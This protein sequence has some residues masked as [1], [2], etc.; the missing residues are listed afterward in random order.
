MIK[1]T[2]EY[3]HHY[4]KHEYLTM[5]AVEQCVLFKQWTI[6]FNFQDPPLIHS[7]THTPTHSFMLST[8]TYDYMP[9]PYFQVSSVKGNKWMPP[10]LC[11]QRENN[12]TTKR[13][14]IKMLKMQSLFL[15]Y[16]EIHNGD[17]LLF[18]F[19]DFFCRVLNYM[20]PR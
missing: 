12:L 6:S 8:N 15:R 14:T 4:E 10:S 16:N 19:V 13:V 11:Q 18:S 7:L 2:R 20:S 9:C 17:N 3:R 5:N 1:K